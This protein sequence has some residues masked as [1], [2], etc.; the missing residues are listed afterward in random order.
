MKT[1]IA[2]LIIFVLLF[3]LVL[4]SDFY[5]QKQTGE[6]LSLACALP[7]SAEVFDNDSEIKEKTGALLSLWRE[8][9]RRF[10]YI[11]SLDV[12]DKAS[13]AAHALYAAAEAGSAEDF[14]PARLRFIAATERIAMLFSVSAES[15]L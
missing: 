11:I 1:F 15:I 3:S 12:S 13:E 10:V 6:L 7:E 4:A 14:L 2:A 9:E 8:S 5:V